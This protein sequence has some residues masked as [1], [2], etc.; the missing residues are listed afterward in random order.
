MEIYIT[1]LQQV[2]SFSSRSRRLEMKNFLSWP[3]M[4]ANNIFISYL[5]NW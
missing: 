3:T 5:E 1:Y 4:L 2:L